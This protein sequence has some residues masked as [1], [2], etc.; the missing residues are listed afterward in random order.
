MW[1][2]RKELKFMSGM[3]LYHDNDYVQTLTDEIKTNVLYHVNKSKEFDGQQ[4]FFSHKE[5][6]V[7]CH[8]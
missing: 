1:V 6:L 8:W 4:E 3:R 2:L 7:M 5:I